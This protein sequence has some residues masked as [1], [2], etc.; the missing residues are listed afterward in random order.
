[1]KMSD[2]DFQQSE[3][4]NNMVLTNYSEFSSGDFNSENLDC[5]RMLNEGNPSIGFVSWSSVFSQIA[6]YA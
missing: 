6:I 2:V 3:S 1:M 5:I 4:T